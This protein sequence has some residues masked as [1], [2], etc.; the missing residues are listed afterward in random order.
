M[1]TLLLGRYYPG[2]SILHRLDPRAKLIGGCYF[3]FLLL[4][5]SNWQA[6]V[7]LWIFT[8]TVMRL[9]GVK[10]SVY[11]RGVKPLI[12]LITFTVFLQV[13]FTAGGTIYVKWGIITISSYG[14]VNGVYIFCRFVMIVFV[15][16]IVTLTTRPIDLTD[17]LNYLIRP[18]SK[19]KVPVDEISLMLTIALRFVPALLDETQKVMDAQRSR[20]TVFGKGS[21]VRQMKTLVPI[22]IP[23]FSSSLERAEQLANAME[24]KGYQSGKSRTTFRKLSWRKK[25]TR[26]LFI[27]MLLTILII[28]L[29]S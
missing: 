4:L 25:D 8:L 20:G 12:W 11:Y 6:Y 10:F 27:L 19:L 1:N 28:L 18:L 29:P 14:L 2:E 16:T 3:I 5:A 17:A 22:F 9:S 7:L 26:S 23:L 15:S 21:I 13:L 24:V